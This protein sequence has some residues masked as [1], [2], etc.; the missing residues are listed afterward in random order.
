MESSQQHDLSNN[1]VSLF[2]TTECHERQIRQSRR[3]LLPPRKRSVMEG[4]AWPGLAPTFVP[5]TH[6]QRS[7]EC[8]RCM[9]RSDR[10]STTTKRAHTRLQ[11]CTQSL[12]RPT[13]HHSSL[14]Q[15][16]SNS[17][18]PNSKAALV[19]CTMSRNNSTACIGQTTLSGFYKGSNN[20]QGRK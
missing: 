8:H 19:Q 9:P 20:K 12:P 14:P 10:S 2:R 11:P 3:H 18:Y 5:H 6:T 15:A 1:R 13:M 4:L 17:I 16:R 7:N